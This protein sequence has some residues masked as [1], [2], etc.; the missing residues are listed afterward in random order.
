MG[1][2]YWNLGLG[3]KFLN[4]ENDLNRRSSQEDIQMANQ[5]M[6]RW[7]AQHH[8]WVSKCKTKST[9]CIFPYSLR[10]P[11]EKKTENNNYWQGYRWIRALLHC[12]L[13][14]K[15]LQ[16]LGKTVWQLLTTLN[17]VLPDIPAIQL[18]IY[19][20]GMKTYIFTQNIHMNVHSNIIHY[21]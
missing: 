1:I 12:C 5:H 20:R 2:N 6:E 3:K 21:S 4:M 10:F 9:W 14:Y 19:L 7:S 18:M 16:A 15:T 13:G 11:V 8:W 17:T